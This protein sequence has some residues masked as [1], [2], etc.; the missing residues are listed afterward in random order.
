MDLLKYLSE[1]NM[2]TQ[3]SLNQE[4]S[5]CECTDELVGQTALKT[6]LLLTQGGQ[7]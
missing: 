1:V 7:R 6:E 2:R 5:S 3:A 4:V